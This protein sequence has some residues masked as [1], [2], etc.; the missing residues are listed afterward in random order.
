MAWRRSK[1]HNSVD[2]IGQ[3]RFKDFEASQDR[4]RRRL[5]EKYGPYQK[6]PPLRAAWRNPLIGL[7]A[8]LLLAL[9][10]LLCWPSAGTAE[11]GLLALAET[12]RRPVS[13]EPISPD[14]GP[15]SA[16]T[17]LDHLVHR[18]LGSYEVGRYAEAAA[19]FTTLSEGATDGKRQ[20]YAYY[21]GNAYYLSQ[22]PG[23]AADIL[24]PLLEELDRKS[25]LHGIT[26]LYLGLVRIDQEQPIAARKVLERVDESNRKAYR[27]AA[28][29][30]DLLRR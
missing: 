1:K 17:E 30:L 4:L 2:E 28:D 10:A 20:L 23:P 18:A 14:R 12:H 5:E 16:P 7:A 21:A 27:Q 24:A 8:A 9:G 26:A 11:N 15:A 22:Q 25:S 13:T 6:P 3:H 19:D 29:L